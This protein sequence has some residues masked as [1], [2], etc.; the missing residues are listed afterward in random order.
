[1]R[2][3]NE[4]AIPNV[5][6]DLTGI[7]V[8]ETQWKNLW[9]AGAKDTFTL[10]AMLRDPEKIGRV[11]AIGKKTIDKLR[12]WIGE[13]GQGAAPEPPPSN[14]QRSD[15]DKVK[16][17]HVIRVPTGKPTLR[18]LKR[19]GRELIQVTDELE[20]LYFAIE[21]CIDESGQIVNQ[22][23]EEEL[24]KFEIR[25]AET[26]E[27]AINLTD[28]AKNERDFWKDKKRGPERRRKAWDT[29]YRTLRR[30]ERQYMITTSQ[31]RIDT[32]SGNTVILSR[33]TDKVDRES[34]DF[35][36]VPDDILDSD[37]FEWVNDGTQR[38][39]DPFIGYVPRWGQ[40]K[41]YLAEKGNQPWCTLRDPQTTRV[42]QIR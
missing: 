11:P 35:S 13:A 4:S 16:A 25:A 34:L 8:G 30:A 39:G 42:L 41:K 1:M 22:E 33:A 40:I 18:S 19:T 24:E 17:D 12:D 26:F 28:L 9:H 5:P 23:F 38:N 32:R 36:K 14:G 6:A 29:F 10:A 15:P 3:K 31:D 37:L 21:G 20:D 27:A 7:P 2:K